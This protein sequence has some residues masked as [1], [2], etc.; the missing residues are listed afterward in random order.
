MYA[1]RFGNDYFCL[2]SHFGI[3]TNGGDKPSTTI[4]YVARQ[5]L[6]SSDVLSLWGENIRFI[7]D[8]RDKGT[9]GNVGR[10][11][12]G[13]SAFCQGLGRSKIENLREAFNQISALVGWFAP[14]LAPYTTVGALAIDGVSTVLKKL[15]DNQSECIVSELSVYPGSI[16]SPLPRGDA[17][18]QTG[19]YVFFYENVPETEMA[20]MFLSRPGQVVKMAANDVPI[21]PYTVINIVDGIIDAPSEIQSRATAVD[22]LEKYQ[23]RYSLDPRLGNGSMSLLT[24]GLQKIGDS[25]YYISSIRRYMDLASKGDGRSSRETTRMNEIKAEIESRFPQVKLSLQ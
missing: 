22:I 20:D 15:V 12:I 1:G 13:T 2:L 9:D 17:Y 3:G 19:S 16:S 24:E 7:K 18:L 5:D 23:S 8:Y 14:W 4:N 6:I 11:F 21:P 10:V 25:Y